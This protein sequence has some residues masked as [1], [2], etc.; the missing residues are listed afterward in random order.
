MERFD[1]G[2][3]SIYG[4][5]HKMKMFLLLLLGKISESGKVF[6]SGNFVE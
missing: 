4:V 1:E 6:Q 2:K 3:A 5:L